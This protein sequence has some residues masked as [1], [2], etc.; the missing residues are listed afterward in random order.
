MIKFLLLPH[1]LHK[2]LSNL[3]NC[4]CMLIEMNQVASVGLLQRMG[5]SCFGRA[6]CPG[7]SRR[8][9]WPLDFIHPAPQSTSSLQPA[10]NGH[11]SA[12][13]KAGGE[14][15]LMTSLLMRVVPWKVHQER[16]Y[17]KGGE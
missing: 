13:G 9:W 16:W 1:S 2:R 7:A 6:S 17:G 5:T 3:L 15:A 14:L 8:L 4:I 10:G 11:A 12:S